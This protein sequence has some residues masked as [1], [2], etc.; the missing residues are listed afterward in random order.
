MEPNGTTNYGFHSES[1]TFQNQ[2]PNSGDFHSAW[3]PA[4]AELPNCPPGVEYLSQID[5][6]IIHQQTEL[7][8]VLTGYE[9][10]NKYEIKN[11]MGQKVYFAAEETSCCN[12]F[13]CGSARSFAIVIT[14]NRGQEV[15]RLLRP[16]RCSCC[17]APCC[18]QNLE[19]QAPPGIPIGYVVQNWH[20]LL[21]KFTIQN[22][23][24]ENVL[25]IIGPCLVCCCCSDINFM[26]KSADEMY[27]VGRISKQWSGL[28]NEMCTDA[29][30]FGVQ[31]PLNL[32]VK[33]KAV[34]LGACFLID[35]MFFEYSEQK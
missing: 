4:P 26:V 24:H 31:F 14:D 10:S 28:V 32:D 2:P 1:P 8:E 21:P 22:E 33:I 16:L 13:F 11:S 5:Q 12:R 7:L 6:L 3:M 18:L 17:F 34:M 9:R 25:R 29:D 35:F 15:I 23:R 19:V 30:I 27:E 20:P